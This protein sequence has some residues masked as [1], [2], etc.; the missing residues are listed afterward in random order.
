MGSCASLCSHSEVVINDATPISEPFHHDTLTHMEA[1]GDASTK[2]NA[3]IET[4]ISDSPTSVTC[5]DFALSLSSVA[6]S[7]ER[8]SPRIQTERVSTGITKKPSTIRNQSIPFILINE[9]AGNRTK[10]SEKRANSSF[11]QVPVH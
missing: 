5:S 10:F 7:P 2:V 9:V 6:S 8:T 1:E 11:L 4:H 3:D